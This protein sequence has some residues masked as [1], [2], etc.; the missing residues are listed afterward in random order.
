MAE[1][2][3]ILGLASQDGPLG[4]EISAAGRIKRVDRERGGFRR[5]DRGEVG[6]V[7][8]LRSYKTLTE[9][10]SNGGCRCFL[11]DHLDGALRIFGRTRFPLVNPTLL[12]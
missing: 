9:K 4:R 10:W 1:E 2:F 6:L 8:Q 5:S 11:D 3:N 12:L 7:V